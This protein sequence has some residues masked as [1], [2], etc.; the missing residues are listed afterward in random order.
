[1]ESGESGKE[2]LKRWDL[3]FE[4]KT[5]GVADR[6]ANSPGVSRVKILLRY[7]VFLRL[8]NEIITINLRSGRF[9]KTAVIGCGLW[10]SYVCKL[11]CD[12]L[13][14]AR[15]QLLCTLWK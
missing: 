14:D 12:W 8:I 6:G 3:S 10:S 4:W 11:T 15:F 9:I 1:M 7:K 2:S 5:R 13:K